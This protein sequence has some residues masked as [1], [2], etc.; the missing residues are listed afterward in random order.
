MERRCDK[1]NR[2]QE[3]QE[4]EGKKAPVNHKTQNIMTEV[5]PNMCHFN[6]NYKWIISIP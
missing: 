6:N 5:L 4:K 1:S 3:R 2:Q